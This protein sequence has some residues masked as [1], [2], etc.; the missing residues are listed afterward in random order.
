MDGTPQPPPSPTEQK[1]L[2]DLQVVCLFPPSY[3]DAILNDIAEDW[4]LSL[5]EVRF[6]LEKYSNL[7][8]FYR[9][10]WTRWLEPTSK[11]PH[12]ITPLV[13]RVRARA[14]TRREL[15]YLGAYSVAA[16]SNA[17]AV[18]LAALERLGTKKRSRTANTLLIMAA[19]DFA[20][21]HQRPP[22]NAELRKFVQSA[23]HSARYEAVTDEN[24]NRHVRNSGV[25]FLF[26]LANRTGG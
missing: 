16:I 5:D 12:E 2:E 9:I 4:R 8:D 18:T 25:H 14:A 3:Q 20:H 6:E 19:L 10:A 15:L 13:A 23:E 22:R 17:D 7:T 1:F 26:A 24:W 11:K 21:R